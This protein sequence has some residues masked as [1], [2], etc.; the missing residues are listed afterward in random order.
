MNNY[1]LWKEPLYPDQVCDTVPSDKTGE[2]LEGR[3]TRREGW[4]GNAESAAKLSPDPV[5]NLTLA[6]HGLGRMR[7]GSDAGDQRPL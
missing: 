1:N 3:G 4:P 7:S 2:R 5:T 6:H